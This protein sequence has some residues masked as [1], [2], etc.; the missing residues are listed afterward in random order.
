[1][2]KSS[3]NGRVSVATNCSAYCASCMLPIRDDSAFE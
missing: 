2:S 3:G 1:L